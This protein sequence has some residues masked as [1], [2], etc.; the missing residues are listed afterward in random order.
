MPRLLDAQDSV[1]S[2]WPERDHRLHCVRVF[3]SLGHRD[4]STRMSQKSRYLSLVPKRSLRD[5]ED[6]LAIV[7]LKQ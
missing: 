7:S 2:P 6:I 5:A 1:M 3:R 4:Q